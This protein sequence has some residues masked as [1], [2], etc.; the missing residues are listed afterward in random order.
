MLRGVHLINTMCAGHLEEAMHWCI[1]QL[2]YEMKEKITK[3]GLCF[4]LVI[5]FLRDKIIVNKVLYQVLVGRE[6]DCGDL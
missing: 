3:Q 5:W 2:L 4:V 1:Y 6:Y